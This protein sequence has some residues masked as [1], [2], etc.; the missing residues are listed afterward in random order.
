M[1]MIGYLA[2][3]A[4]MPMVPD[5]PISTIAEF[6][7]ICAHKSFSAETTAIKEL[8]HNPDHVRI[9]IKTGQPE[10]HAGYQ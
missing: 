8:R 6:A 3:E 1:W 2:S 4:Y 5:D 9:F 7:T 10:G